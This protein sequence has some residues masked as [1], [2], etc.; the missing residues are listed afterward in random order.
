MSVTNGGNPRTRR[1]L[2]RLGVGALAVVAAT[3]A[4]GPLGAA[5]DDSPDAAPA[6]SAASRHLAANSV[7]ELPM[8]GGPYVP[9]DA[10]AVA[11]NVTATNPTTAGYVSLYPCGQGVPQVSNVNFVQG[12]TVAN[13][14]I[15]PL[16]VDG[17]VCVFAFSPVNVVID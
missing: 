10:S 4:I 7:T 6:P 2:T 11:L 17:K 1:L 12:Q 5:A 15:V 14:A 16:G 9:A 8:G 3:A 13:A